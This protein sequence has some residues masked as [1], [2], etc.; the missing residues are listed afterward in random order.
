MTAAQKSA[1]DV[2][3]D[4]KVDAKDASSIL[5]YYALV[6][7]ASGDIPSMKEFMTPKQT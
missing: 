7:T 5:A 3:G 2:N 1:A 4:D 6:S